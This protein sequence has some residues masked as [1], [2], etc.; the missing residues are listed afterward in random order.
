MKRDGVVQPTQEV[1]RTFDLAGDRWVL[2]IVR[3]LV[4]GRSRYESMAVD[5]GLAR[6]V[7]ASRLRRLVAEDVLERVQY[8]ERPDRFEYRLTAKGRGLVPVVA[9]LDA[10]SEQWRGDPNAA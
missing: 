1:V 4:H 2:L 5:L 7:L 9:A 10:L 3:E 8:Q 6:N